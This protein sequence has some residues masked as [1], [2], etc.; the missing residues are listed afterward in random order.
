VT[1][2][3]AHP[4][5]PSRRRRARSAAAAVLLAAAGISLAAAWA[6]AQTGGGRADM[7]GAR[8]DAP[9]NPSGQPPTTLDPNL[10]Q[11]NEALRRQR[12]G[13]EAS[14]PPGLRTRPDS[15]RAVADPAADPG[16]IGALAGKDGKIVL[17]FDNESVELNVFADYVSK[18]LG[19]NIYVD[20]GLS[21]Q[22][23][24]FKAPLE[25]PISRLLPL[26]SAFV[27]DRGF[28]LVKHP[29]GWYQIQPAANVVPNIEGD[30]LSTTRVIRTPLVKP[31]S[32]QAAIQTS[33]GNSAQAARIT[34]FD[35]IGA[36]MVT[37]T[38]RTVDSIS[39]LVERLML[40]ISDQV[41]TRFELQNVAADYA[42]DR[43]LLLNGKLGASIGGAPGGVQPGGAVAVGSLSNFDSRLIVDQGNSLIFRGTPE[44]AREVETLVKMVD[45]V[46]PLTS[47][48]YTVGPSVEE[49]A[50]AGQMMGLGSVGYS[51]SNAGGSGG[52]STGFRPGQQGLGGVSAQQ[53]VGGSHFTVDQQSGSFTFFGNEA[54]HKVVADLVKSFTEQQVSSRV[55]IRMYKLHNATADSV[56]DLLN[57][58][59]QDPSQRLGSS[60]FLPG[61][62]V[63]QS[64]A[65]QPT[66]STLG[67][68]ETTDNPIPTTPAG[69][70]ATAGVSLTANQDE[71]SIVSDV[72]RNQ[73]I[74]RASARQ[75][76]E[77]ERIIRAL[78]ERQRQ[79]YIEAQI[80]AVRTND[81]FEWTVE[82][83]I[84]AGD[85]LLF[86][87]FGLSVPQI[88]D[89]QPTGP[90]QVPANNRG[91]TTAVVRSDYVPFILRTLQNNSDARIVSYP[92][93]LV[94]DNLQGTV[95]S[96]RDEPYSVTSQGT[97]TT[98]TG[99]GGVA[100][101]GT[102]L[103]VTPRISEGGYI[104]LE[105]S[106]EL[107]NFDRTVAQ[108]QGLQP[109]TQRE[110][111]NSTVQVPSDSTIVVGGFTLASFDESES[112][113]PLLGDI[114]YIGSLFK[115]YSRNKTKTTIFLFIT[116]TIMSDQDSLDLRLVSEGPM[117]EMGLDDQTPE[118]EPVTIPIS[119]RDL[120]AST[121]VQP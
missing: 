38:P 60:P 106:F 32:L 2:T 119:E 88:V 54:Q 94:L 121:A 31:S 24:I 79:V 28:A 21:N 20:E 39:A 37:G 80:V 50:Q 84:N 65:Q 47:K 75:Q 17:N 4:L 35:E 53:D 56:A 3:T 44:E 116:P 64:R 13:M 41:L 89:G 68:P 61:S 109:P 57:E 82:T 111:Y 43:I 58:L 87:N 96:E 26:L 51:Q 108:S 91:L 99:Q 81:N 25:V 107:S 8:P 101:A 63:S 72:D 117:R 15:D 42:R 7:P 92:R 110:E 40:E 118:L 22:R 97:A 93:L 33:L 69:D 5:A 104:S 18:A 113:I 59:I 83:Q 55:E 52:F 23:I 77:F 78:D 105:Y 71:V 30:N 34:A 45:I 9:T 76:S 46:T 90:K 85:F 100:T 1:R 27:E 14:L 114:P 112:K 70:G 49:V 73:V 10:E 6:F 120:L 103:E 66:A 86:S 67:V 48:R 98:T 115:S 12:D 11:R 62:R 16:E 74:I 95:S 102:R 19:V 36:L 29:L